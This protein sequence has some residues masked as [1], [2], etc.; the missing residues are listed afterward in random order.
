M[1]CVCGLVSHRCCRDDRRAFVGIV[2]GLTSFFMSGIGSTF[3]GTLVVSWYDRAFWYRWLLR[4][5][6][7]IFTFLQHDRPSLM[8]CRGKYAF[9]YAFALFTL[10]VSSLWKIWT[11]R[12]ISTLLSRGDTFICGLFYPWTVWLC[13]IIGITWTILSSNL[14]TRAFLWLVS[15]FH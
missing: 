14:Y 12:G 5:H 11:D 8:S 13:G 15:L 2:V 9:S 1:A 6:S 10:S 3:V 7:R 4:N